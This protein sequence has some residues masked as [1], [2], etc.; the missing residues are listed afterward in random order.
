MNP[1]TSRAARSGLQDGYNTQ[2]RP[3]APP[4]WR[5][6]FLPCKL[7]CPSPRFANFFS[8]HIMLRRLSPGA[9]LLSLA[10]HGTAVAQQQDST[11]RPSQAG[12]TV[13]RAATKPDLQL[14][15][16]RSINLDT[17]EGTWI[18]LDVSPD[19]RNVVFDLLG[20]L[21]LMP[22]SG[23][24]ATSLT[25]GMAFDAQPRSAPDGRSVVFTSDRDGGDNVWTIDIS[26][27]ETKLITKGKTSRYRSPEWTPD[28][29]YIVVSR[30]AAAIGPSKLY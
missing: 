24:S 7:G 27:R 14:V 26:T 18:S 8:F 15:A 12:D 30:A 2:T 9:L 13:R 28:G 6:S 11:H 22:I 16:G 23:G 4:H 3:V 10:F 17:D 29:K 20:D 21:Y 19:G 25:S 5:A 1:C